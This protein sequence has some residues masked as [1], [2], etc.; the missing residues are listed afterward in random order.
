MNVDENA[1]MKDKEKDNYMDKFPGNNIFS[2]NVNYNINQATQFI[3]SSTLMC[4]FTKIM[5]IDYRTNCIIVLCGKDQID[6]NK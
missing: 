6:I 5:T 4:T 1:P 2:Q 3:L